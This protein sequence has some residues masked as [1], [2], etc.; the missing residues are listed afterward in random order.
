MPE[1]TCSYCRRSDIDAQEIHCPAC[2]A[3]LESPVPGTALPELVPAP[4]LTALP[5]TMADEMAPMPPLE[6]LS[7]RKKPSPLLW[8]GIGAVGL[9]LLAVLCAVIFTLIVFPGRRQQSDLEIFSVEVLRP[10]IT[11]RRQALVPSPTPVPDLSEPD[12]TS[13]PTPTLLPTATLL[14]SPTPRP[15]GS[16]YVGELAPEFTLLDANSGDSIT[17][18]AFTGQPVLVHFWTTWCGYC[19]DEFIALQAVYE[20]HQADG[21]VILAVD[22][23]DRRSDVVSYGAAH[24]LTFPLLLDDDGSITD[25]AYQVNGFPTTFFIYPDGVIA[26]I[27][28][29][30]LESADLS[31]RLDEILTP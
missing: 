14:P 9:C 23:E 13:I 16:P 1:L 12:P 3:P 25:D 7:G 28:I 24:G 17:L 18:S 15:A 31:Q 30:T 26:S 19:A 2:G 6:E 22:Y 11:P 20:T 21:L 4:E 10:T 8:F 5:E 29:G 27:Q